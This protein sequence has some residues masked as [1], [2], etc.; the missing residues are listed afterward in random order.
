MYCIVYCYVF[1]LSL[2]KAFLIMPFI[3]KCL[4][5]VVFLNYNISF[6]LNVLNLVN[7]P[8]KISYSQ[9][10]KWQNSILE[11]YM[12]QQNSKINTKSEYVGTLLILQHKPLG[13]STQS[14]S[15]P[16]LDK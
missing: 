14:D 11:S 12:E 2:L 7:S 6:K 3:L 1:F 15:G 9:G 4:L 10:L 13:S 5:F 16:G 8:E